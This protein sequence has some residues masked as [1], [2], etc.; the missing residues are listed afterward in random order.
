MKRLKS[1]IASLMRHFAHP[2]RVAEMLQMKRRI[3]VLENMQA[4][5]KAFA[6][7]VEL[8]TGGNLPQ[9]L[10]DTIRALRSQYETLEEVRKIMYKRLY[11]LEAQDIRVQAAE[12]LVRTDL[13]V[14]K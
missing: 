14:T 12:L 4:E 5:I 13:G 1:W 8:I 7:K 3:S 11:E 9:D 10:H 6:A 2:P